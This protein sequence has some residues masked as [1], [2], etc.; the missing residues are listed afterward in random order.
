MGD[1]IT[2]ALE[3]W[4]KKQKNKKTKKD[5]K[6]KNRKRIQPRKNPIHTKKTTT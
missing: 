2:K 6:Q 3:E 1:T 5:L 4:L